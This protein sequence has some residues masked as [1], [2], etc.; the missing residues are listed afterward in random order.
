MGKKDT[1]D[2]MEIEALGVS[3]RVP[4]WDDMLSNKNTMNRAKI[5]QAMANLEAKM[6]LE[7]APPPT[8][9]TI[10]E[11]SQRLGGTLSDTSI[12]IVSRHIQKLVDDQH[13]IY[14]K[15]DSR[16]GDRG[17]PVGAGTSPWQTQYVYP[18]IKRALKNLKNGDRE[19]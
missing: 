14:P 17:K 15:G 9:Y 12:S 4:G 2:M 19:E 6:Y 3:V 8:Q 7:G 10:L 18:L 5:L 11:E 16:S 1:E 13:V